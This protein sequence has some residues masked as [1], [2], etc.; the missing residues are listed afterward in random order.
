MKGKDVSV[1]T[2]VIDSM[3]IIEAITYFGLLIKLSAGLTFGTIE[4]SRNEYLN[5]YRCAVECT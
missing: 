2:A 4:K 5:I 3:K 1:N